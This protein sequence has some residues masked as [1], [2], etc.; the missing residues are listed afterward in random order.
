VQILPSALQPGALREVWNE[1]R[2][3]H[4]ADDAHAPHMRAAVD[5]LTRAQDATESGGIARGYSLIWNR[6]FEVRGWE[7]A[8]PETTGYIIPTLMATSRVLHREELLDRAI[9]AAKW[10]C[11]IQM[12]SGAVQGGVLGEDISP[13]IF[14]TGQVIFGWLAAYQHTGTAKFA[15]AAER[16]ATYLASRLDSD[17]IWRRDHSRYA[18]RGK[19]LY[20]AR[21][22]WA[23]AEAGS[24]LGIKCLLDAA[25]RSLRAIAQCQRPNS[26]FPDCCL[27][28]PTRPLLHTIA[29]AIRGLLEGGRV[30][31][32]AALIDQAA[33]AAAAV[34][35]EVDEQGRLPGRLA[36]DWRPAARWSCLTGQAQMVN[37]WIRLYEITGERY[38][39]EPVPRVL[40]YLKSTQNRESDDPGL[41]G[42]I[43]GSDPLGGEYGPYEV[44]SWATKFF[45]DA[46]LRH[47]RVLAGTRTAP[48]DVMLLA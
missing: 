4:C 28:D 45:I 19:S 30:L 20:N 27:T 44:L 43:K 1:R 37:I 41:R 48:D 34:A 40:Q 13:A 8:Y 47:D 32:D 9:C 35:A 42:G 36:E 11:E 7:P 25:A 18:L 16:A 31:G 33:A 12:P 21:T 14:N 5:W 23:M 26:W 38:W 17:G 46:L 22:A 3:G 10:E 15:V 39:L 29:Y 24:R 2:G 6:Y